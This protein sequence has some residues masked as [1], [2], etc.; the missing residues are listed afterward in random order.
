MELKT[1][2]IKR[3][4]IYLTDDQK[5]VLSKISENKTL[6]LSDTYALRK[7]FRIKKLRYGVILNMP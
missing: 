5:N 2:V 3:R 4:N 7:K 6:R 1:K